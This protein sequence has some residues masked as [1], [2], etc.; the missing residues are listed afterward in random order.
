[1]KQR[2][3]HTLLLEMQ[4]DT[5]I[6][7]S[8]LVAFYKVKHTLINSTIRHLPKKNKNLVSITTLGHEH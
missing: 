7:G 8:I 4:D 5:I 3:F 2:N 6:W 1:M